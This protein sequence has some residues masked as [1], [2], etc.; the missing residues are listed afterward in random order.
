[1]YNDFMK[2]FSKKFLSCFFNCTRNTF[3]MRN[4]AYIINYL[5]LL[6]LP[7]IY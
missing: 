4:N 1:M 3:Y 6:K 5:F 7:L 2:L